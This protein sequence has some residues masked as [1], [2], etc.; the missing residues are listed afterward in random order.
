MSYSVPLEAVEIEGEQY[1]LAFI[2]LRS[3]KN[4]AWALFCRRT[5]W[6][7]EVQIPKTF[8]TLDLGDNGKHIY[9][10]CAPFYLS[11]DECDSFLEWA[12]VKPN[13]DEELIRMLHYKQ[14]LDSL[15]ENP[16]TKTG[17]S[18]MI[19]HTLWADQLS[20]HSPFLGN[21]GRMEE[22]VR[23]T[24]SS[25]SRNVA[26]MVSNRTKE[27]LQNSWRRSNNMDSRSTRRVRSRS[28]IKRSR[29]SGRPTQQFPETKHA[30]MAIAQFYAPLQ[31]Y[32]QPQMAMQQPQ[33]P[34]TGT[35]QLHQGFQAQQWNH[36]I[37]GVAGQ[38]QP[39]LLYQPQH[40]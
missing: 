32:L 11:G 20:I 9:H 14:T 36:W 7:N 2:I 22:V 8:Y 4:N 28:Q 10:P 17:I 37:A 13:K 38:P 15:L 39:R 35:Q 3:S 30:Q 40:I 18:S 23:R 6:K 26:N 16:D 33:Q 27:E 1:N 21:L 29:S 24:I 12:E 19:Q 25:S 31:Y 5:D 34:T